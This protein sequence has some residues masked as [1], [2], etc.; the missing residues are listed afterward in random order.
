MTGPLTVRL[1]TML[2]EQVIGASKL[3]NNRKWIAIGIRRRAVTLTTA[4][5]VAT[6][7]CKKIA[8]IAIQN[9]SIGEVLEAP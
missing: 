3:Q 6:I 2:N 7:L 9:V 1:S 5:D 4:F 8:F